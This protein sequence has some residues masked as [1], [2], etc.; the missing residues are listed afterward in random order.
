[1]VADLD[2]EVSVM[3]LV[4]LV[5]VGFAP[6]RAGTDTT[7]DRFPGFACGVRFRGS[8]RLKGVALFEGILRLIGRVVV[9]CDA[10][11]P[12]RLPVAPITAFAPAATATVPKSLLMSPLM[13]SSLL[14]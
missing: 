12:I 9:A 11:L 10:R 3:G 2:V 5:A 14:T 13:S 4:I 6:E 8:A 1:M 7:S